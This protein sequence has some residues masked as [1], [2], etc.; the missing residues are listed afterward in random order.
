MNPV[1][2]LYAY[3]I[4]LLIL[5]VVLFVAILVAFL[6]QVF[7]KQPYGGLL[8]FF[9][10]PILMIGLPSLQSFKI[11]GI[12]ADL[13][14]KTQAVQQDP[15]DQQARSALQQDAQ[16]LS[17]RPVTNAATNANL[18]EAQFALGNE[19]A[20]KLNLQKALQAD[21]NLPAAQDVKRKIELSDKLATLVPQVE[22][23]PAND[24]ARRE[25]NQTVG[26]LSHVRVAN[27]NTVAQMAQAYAVLGRAQEARQHLD[28]AAKISPS[29]PAVKA[30][31]IK[32]K[33]MPVTMPAEHQ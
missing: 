28:V 6:R 3:E 2:G 9:V 19:Q 21:P 16:A 5:G 26:E 23:A 14:A 4:V 27:P 11:A 25:L 29:A 8:A 22:A 7:T 33:S 17:S 30:A 10:L 31:Q 24:A 1:D 15:T 32:L 20:A 13:A 12:E 18:A